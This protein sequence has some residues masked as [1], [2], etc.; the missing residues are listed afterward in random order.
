MANFSMRV[1][2]DGPIFYFST[3]YVAILRT[4][5]RRS[6]RGGPFSVPFRNPPPNFGRFLTLSDR[7]FTFSSNLFRYLLTVYFSPVSLLFFRLYF[8]FFLFSPFSP[9]PFTFFFFH[10]HPRFPYLYFPRFPSPFYFSHIIFV[11]F[12]S[13]SIP[14]YF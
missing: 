5:A 11:R 9:L 7:T 1:A 8:I 13:I 14:F 3:L 12:H 10:F 6:P 4:A 2:K